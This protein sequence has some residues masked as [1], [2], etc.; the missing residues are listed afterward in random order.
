M[1]RVN[2]WAAASEM[3]F[4]RLEEI[5][6]QEMFAFGHEADQGKFST[7]V[8]IDVQQFGESPI[9]GLYYALRS[10]SARPSGLLANN[11]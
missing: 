10:R 6:E 4:V 8:V 7:W 1:R 2:S 11:P 5:L 3:A 9:V